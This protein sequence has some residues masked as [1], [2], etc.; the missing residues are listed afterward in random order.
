MK[1]IV[2]FI[3]ALISRVALWFRYRIK[4][5]GL[6]KL[7][8]ETLS[9]P[10]G[11]LFLPSHPTYF[12]DPIINTLAV[13]PKYVIRPMVVE[14]MYYA[15]LIY[16]IM[17]FLDALPIP[18]FTTSSNSLKRNKS[19]KALLEV[20]KGLK[21]GSNF[22][23]YPGGSVK[24]TN[25]EAI[26]GAS[27]AHRI[28]QDAPEA[29]VVLV[30][31]KGLWGSSFSR[32][33]ISKPQTAGEALWN[34]LKIIFKNLI[35]FT[36]RREVIVEVEPAPADFPWNASRLDFNRYLERWYNKPDGLSDVNTGLPGDSLVLVSYSMWRN[37]YLE[38]KVG[39]N[40][41]KGINI[42]GI[43]KSVQDKVI[44]KLSEISETNPALIKPDMNLAKH[45][46][47]DSL[48]AAE[49]VTFLNDEFD[50]SGVSVNELSTVGKLMAIASKQL[51]I[52]SQVHELEQSNATW[53]KK[54]PHQPIH[55]KVAPTIHETFLNT[56]S[57][58]GK[59]AACIDM[60]SGVQTYADMRLRAIVLAEQ[61][62][63]M[64]G[65]YIGIM[66]PA[67]VGATITVF[68]TLLAGKVPV[69]V[70]WTV[71]PRH[72]E[73]VLSVTKLEVVLSSWAFLD[74]L[75]NANLDGIEDQLVMLEDVSRQITL[76]QKMKGLFL[77]KRSTKAILS[78]FGSDA[79]HEDD[80]AV[81]LFTSG[82]ESVPKGV[83][84]THRNILQNL[85]ATVDYIDIIEDDIL[86][87]ILPPFHSFGFSVT[88]LLGPLLGIRVAYSPNPTD[89]SQLASGIKAWKPTV[90]VGAPTFL[91][92]ILKSTD[93]EALKQVRLCVTGAEKA[94]QELFKLVEEKIGKDCVIEGYGIT[95]C[96]PILTF[97]RQNEPRVGV[98]QA[99][100]NVELVIINPETM[101]HMPMGQQGMI[102]VRGPNIF[103][104]YLNPGLTSP[105]LSIDGKDWY[106]TGDLGY[107]DEKGNLTIGG[108][109]KRFI[110]IGGEMVSLAAVEEAL[111]KFYDKQGLPLNP[112]GPSLAICAKEDSEKAKIYLFSIDDIS[113]EDA[114]RALREWGFSNLVKLSSVIK[115]GEIPVMGTGKI[116]YRALEGQY[117]A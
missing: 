2:E 16:P 7:N 8:S 26:G 107:L 1:S 19:E 38:P 39:K 47:L 27:G 37:E 34:G 48:D 69:M 36:P 89:G 4:V 66:L 73:S 103:S 44:Q 115:L 53:D 87:G 30:R 77:S 67:S 3:I 74:R 42:A 98:G 6:E 70:N 116:N 51:V 49:L 15:P 31:I 82:T 5:V 61:I 110:K 54:I 102:M 68:A 21:Q 101:E 109:L 32:A 17:K 13:Y 25:Y 12:I 91:R 55:L 41:E 24:H 105:F 92:T 46:G 94:P 40:V 117:L 28:V 88:T 93:K 108:R 114:N 52:E 64:P 100:E 90:I 33:I 11:V 23:I 85:R 78:H 86:F 65:E 80:K 95:E 59:A 104:G 83:P 96:S 10:G 71:G 113:L 20:I 63:K 50:V 57:K 79:K 22:M 18:N 111:L 84:L 112:E 60:R 99:I 35:F 76:T 14:Y 106:K 58:R 9:K 29:N 75:E 97:N 45:L 72:L 56:T 62:R 81:V 43:D